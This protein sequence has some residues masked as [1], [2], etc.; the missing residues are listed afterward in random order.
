MLLLSFFTSQTRD[1]GVYATKNGMSYSP[2]H[3]G[4]TVEYTVQPTNDGKK[5]YVE[6]STVDKLIGWINQ[7]SSAVL[8]GQVAEARSAFSGPVTP[9]NQMQNIDMCID[10]KGKESHKKYGEEKLVTSNMTDD[11]SSQCTSAN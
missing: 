8:T 6:F 5:L 10:S 2:E 11:W 4:D 9:Q 7:F 3:I 1:F